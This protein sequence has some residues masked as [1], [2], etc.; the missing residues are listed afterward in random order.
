M[1][2]VAVDYVADGAGV[3]TGEQAR[4][5]ATAE[6][7][8]SIARMAP[9]LQACEKCGNQFPYTAPGETP[10]CAVCQTDPDEVAN[11]EAAATADLERPWN[12]VVNQDKVNT[13]A[14]LKQPVQKF[15]KPPPNSRGTTPAA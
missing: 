5:R 2:Y 12:K 1:N 4:T 15:S 9:P 8:A 11:D 13:T 10:V 14:T 6:H 3:S 7:L